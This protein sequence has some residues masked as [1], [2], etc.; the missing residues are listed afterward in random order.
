MRVPHVL[1]GVLVACAALHAQITG[2]ALL[3]CYRWGASDHDGHLYLISLPGRGRTDLISA[4]T[5]GL[6]ELRG[7]QAAT[8]SRDG[9]RVAYMAELSET[10]GQ[11][12]IIDNDGANHVALCR[13]G[14]SW[15]HYQLS[16]VGEWIYWTE[17]PGWPAE[18]NRE[19]Y[20]VSV[21]TGER[22]LFHR[23]EV[24]STMCYFLMADNSTHGLA[25]SG[26]S[27][28]GTFPWP[29]NPSNDWILTI[30]NGRVLDEQPGPG[31]ACFPSL[32]PGGTY[33][34][35]APGTMPPDW[36][37][38]VPARPT[39]TY[40]RFGPVIQINHP[41][42]Q[43]QSWDLAVDTMVWMPPDAERELTYYCW[44]RNSE[45]VVCA[46]AS[47][48]QQVVLD[49]EN[50]TVDSLNY[51][52]GIRSGFTVSSFWVGTLPSPP[53]DSPRI[54][55]EPAMTVLSSADQHTPAVDTLSVVNTSGGVLGPIAYAA[56][57]TA[58]WLEISTIS[59]GGN[60]QS[61]RLSADPA[62]LGKG[63]CYATVRAYGG[64]ASN[65]SSCEVM[66][67]VGSTVC[68]P[69][70]PAATITEYPHLHAAIVWVDNA[71]NESGFLVER[72]TSGEQ[73]RVLAVLGANTTAYADNSVVR[74][75]LYEYRICAYAVSDTSGYSPVVSA[76]FSTPASI[77]ITGPTAGEVWF[78]GGAARVQFS[79]VHVNLVAIRLS[80]DD[81]ETWSVV[82]GTHALSS[83]DTNW[84]NFAVAVPDTQSS[85]CLVSVENYMDPSIFARSSRFEI[86]A[87]GSAQ[88]IPAG[89]RPASPLAP[90]VIVTGS[91][92][93]AP[94]LLSRGFQMYQLDGSR[95]DASRSFAA[96]DQN[97]GLGHA[98]YLL[99]PSHRSHAK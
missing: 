27:P 41:N 34:I 6:P 77:T 32:S 37:Q 80:L 29:V 33:Y 18:D 94:E 46:A 51:N 84:G 50:G 52:A 43:T 97:R 9:R 1:A 79:T 4:Q 47:G 81:G 42:W 99:Q 58:T 8:F 68:A 60:Q 23:S 10:E 87:E 20:R 26:P 96:T 39:Y 17:C 24:L 14:V 36:Q 89:K 56:D 12:G 95:V 45:H 70:A 53:P 59:S 98:V 35:G 7:I 65:V 85:L 44:A 72:R 86:S 15:E 69:G 55:F 16:W 19:I 11:I 82:S 28:S 49:F 64:G 66:F 57:T 13:K 31:A 83:A 2:S 38:I 93:S 73:W 92:P 90:V 71:D 30:E 48:P 78:P 54:A 63:T 3:A 88:F 75:V 76:T 25:W 74:D 67:N 5:L 91:R 22:E 61:L 40:H 21:R 62:G